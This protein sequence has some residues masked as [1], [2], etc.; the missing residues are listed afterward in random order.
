LMLT[1]KILFKKCN[2]Q[3]RRAIQ[4]TSRSFI[5]T[6]VILRVK[7]TLWR[8]E[9]RLSQQIQEKIREETLLDVT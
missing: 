7:L 2:R 5:S 8:V 6:K 3:A 4:P 9:R 1:M